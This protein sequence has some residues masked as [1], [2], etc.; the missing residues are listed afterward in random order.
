ML[1]RAVNMLTQSLDHKPQLIEKSDQAIL[2]LIKKYGER[3][4]LFN[5]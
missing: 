2:M 3:F 4:C 5:L 1:P